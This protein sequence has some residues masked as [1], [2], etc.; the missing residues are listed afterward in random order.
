MN[1][2]IVHT[3]SKSLTVSVS[4]NDGY[5]DKF[6]IMKTGP[7]FTG[8][9][10][11]GKYTEATLSL[12]KTTDYRFRARIQYPNL[13]MNESQLKSKTKIVEGSNLEYDAVKGTEK[14]GMPLIEIK[15]YQM[16]LKIV[17]L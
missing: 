15:G 8:F 10:I 4:E 1:R 12:P 11:D 14:E 6:T 2:N 7:D 17:E 9:S 5:E 13:E 16:G 3:G